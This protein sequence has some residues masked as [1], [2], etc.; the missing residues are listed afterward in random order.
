MY[1]RKM[2]ILALL[3]SHFTSMNYISKEQIFKLNLNQNL[4]FT[5]VT[6]NNI[7]YPYN[8]EF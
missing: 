2:Y 1:G 3:H 7:R 4:T 8:F 6:A 5:K